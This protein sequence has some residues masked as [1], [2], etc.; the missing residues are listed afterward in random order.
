M[1]QKFTTRDNKK[2]LAK[3]D[4]DMIWNIDYVI[5]AKKSTSNS[6]MSLK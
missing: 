1:N 6:L 4:V 3:Y 2:N 5:K